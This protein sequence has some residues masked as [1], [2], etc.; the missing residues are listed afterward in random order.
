MLGF[1]IKYYFTIKVQSSKIS[2]NPKTALKERIINVIISNKK[3]Y[4]LTNIGVVN[5]KINSFYDD[6]KVYLTFP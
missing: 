6:A 4:S 5:I 2:H 3:N 1:K